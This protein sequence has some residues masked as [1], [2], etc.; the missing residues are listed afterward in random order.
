MMITRRPLKGASQTG[1]LMHVMA[2]YFAMDMAPWASLS[3]P[4]FYEVMKKIPFNPDPD[5]KEFLKRPKFTMD[6]WGPGGD[7]DDKSIAIA[8]WAI[9]KDIPYRF[10]GV[11]NKKPENE[12]ILL[13]HVYPELYIGREWIPFDATYGF[14]ILGK[15]LPK[16]DKK[17]ILKAR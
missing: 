7:C 14:N 17:V 8:A 3:Y 12:K 15:T 16:Y 4:E 13:H 10:V 1:R 6:K 2:R 5:G 11:G 9:L